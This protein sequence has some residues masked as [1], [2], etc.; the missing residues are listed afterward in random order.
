MGMV[1]IIEFF[2]AGLSRSVT[3]GHRRV[4]PKPLGDASS[5]SM[6]RTSEKELAQGN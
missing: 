2:Q 6:S 4:E 5:R 1:R 3:L